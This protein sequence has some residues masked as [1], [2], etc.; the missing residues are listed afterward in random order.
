MLSKQEEYFLTIAE[1][2]SVSRAAQR[3]YLTQP[4]LSGSLKRLEEEMGAPL[5]YRDAYPL[6]LTPAGEVLCRYVREE[7]DREQA[8]RQELARLE[9]EPSGTVRAG[10]NF[11]RSSLVLPKVLPAFLA[12]YPKIRVESVEGSHQE[13][14]A[15]LDQ[16]K[17]D[18]ALLHRPNPYPQFPF[19]RLRWEQILLAVRRDAPALAAL[20]PALLEGERPHLSW[21]ALGVFRDTPFLLL[22]KGQNLREQADEIFRSAG[23]PP[24][25]ALTTSNLMTAL[26]LAAEGAG[27]AFVSDA[28]FSGGPL[29]PA[30]RFFTVG[31]PPARWETGF[32]FRPGVPA[33]TP[34]RLLVRAIQ[35]VFP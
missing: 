11:W 31:D 10:F 20:P 27:A 35:D 16:G 12:K 34:T 18:F 2:G 28:I 19:T 21:E 9:R 6:R 13:L 24:V 15:R 7:R 29:S 5:F 26:N 32:A 8:L 22:K 25:A 4:A 1:A 23:F 33:S 30:L 3:L 17:L 14:A